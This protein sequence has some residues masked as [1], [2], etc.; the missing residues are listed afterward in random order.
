MDGVAQARDFILKRVGESGYNR[1]FTALAVFYLNEI[2]KPYSGNFTVWPRSHHVM[3]A[4]FKERGHEIL[5]NYMPDVQVPEGP[6]QITG[7]HGDL[8]L[9]HHALIHTGAQNISSN[10]RYA[11]ICRPKHVDIEEIGLDALLDIW[12]EWDGI[13]EAVEEGPHPPAPSP[14]TREGH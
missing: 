12:R 2:P 10:I 14:V 1:N 5:L 4:V 6:V 8:I 13:R 11:V 9:G 7:G 3:E